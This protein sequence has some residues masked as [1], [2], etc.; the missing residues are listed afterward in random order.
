MGFDD[1]FKEE[2]HRWIQI[3]ASGIKNCLCPNNEMSSSGLIGAPEKL[4]LAS[5]PGPWLKTEYPRPG[6]RARLG[7]ASDAYLG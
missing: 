4:A 3:D 2:N 5:C 1:G 7:S 6:G